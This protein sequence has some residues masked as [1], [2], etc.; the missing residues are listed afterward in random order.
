MKVPLKCQSVTL[1]GVCDD[2]MAVFEAFK[3]P[4]FIR[5]NGARL[6]W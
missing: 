2:A 3:K 5:R 4:V 1:K 6:K